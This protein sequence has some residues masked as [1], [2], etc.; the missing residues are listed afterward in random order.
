MGIEPYLIA[1]T[2]NAIIG[3]RLVR[4]LDDNKEE[5][6]ADDV[7]KQNILQN[8]SKF[9]PA[10]AADVELVKQDL[11]YDF[12]PV[13]NQ[14]EFKL[15]RGVKSKKAPEGYSGRVGIY[16]VMD[17]SYN[18]QE[19]ILQEASATTLEEAA[20]AEGMVTMHED[21]F[22]KAL[23]GLTSLSEV[24][25]VT[26]ASVA[27]TDNAGSQPGNTGAD[28]VAQQQEQQIEGGS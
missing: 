22:L 1:S 9:L 24:N 28:G 17:V 10:T 27:D 8:L 23:N 3:Q 26:A 21:G 12:I 4:R 7:E 14:Q 18:I 11:G 15:Y 19:L 6:V 2:V 25:R 16:E 13:A 5:Y 20:R